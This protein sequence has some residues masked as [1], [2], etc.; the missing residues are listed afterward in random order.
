MLQHGSVLLGPDHKRLVDYLNLHNDLEREHLKDEIG[1]KTIDLSEALGRAVT[2]DSCVE[3]VKSGFEE[4][5]EMNFET[6]NFET[7]TM[8]VLS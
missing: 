8:G 2:F 5:W 4:A 1:A 3:A 7:V 6:S